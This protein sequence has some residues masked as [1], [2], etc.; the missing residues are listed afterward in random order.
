MVFNAT[1]NNILVIS[2]MA[3]NFIGGWN[4]SARRNYRLS[5]VTD[6]LFHITLH[7]VH[8]AWAGLELTILVMIGTNCIGSCKFNYHTIT[9]TTTTGCFLVFF[10]LCLLLL[11]LFCR[12]G[13]WSYLFCR[14]GE[15]SYLFCIEYILISQLVTHRNKKS[16]HDLDE[17]L[18][19]IT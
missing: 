15:W 9:T 14:G 13:E 18:N 7:R 2:C 5:Q 11:L 6:K 17:R 8:L 3:V 16:M 1:F 12:G 19:V 10:F 4:R